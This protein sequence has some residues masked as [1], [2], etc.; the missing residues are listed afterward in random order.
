MIKLRYIRVNIL[1]DRFHGVV[2]QDIDDLARVFGLTGGVG[3]P[4]SFAENLRGQRLSGNWS[5]MLSGEVCQEEGV[6]KKV[7]G[8]RCQEE[9]ARP[10]S[11]PQKVSNEWPQQ[12]NNSTRGSDP[13]PHS[14]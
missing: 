10:R 11:L 4:Y 1:H 14:R 6:R 13:G 9:G 7:S 5:G 8:R 12:V 3:Q 2:A